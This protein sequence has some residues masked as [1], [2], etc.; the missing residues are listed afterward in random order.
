MHTAHVSMLGVTAVFVYLTLGACSSK[1]LAAEG[2]PFYSL[3]QGNDSQL[4]IQAPQAKLFSSQQELE[5]FWS[6]GPSLL[7]TDNLSPDY[8]DEILLGVFLGPS[9][10]ATTFEIH[11]IRLKDDLT[12]SATVSNPASECAVI[13]VIN[14]PFHLISLKRDALPNTQPSVKLILEETSRSCN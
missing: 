8:T 10:G 9:G 3:I 12:V 1:E 4:V 6:A 5:S 14:M 2:L 11:E 13:A 7:I